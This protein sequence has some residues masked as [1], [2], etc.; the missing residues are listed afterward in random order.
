[1]LL[2]QK[3]FESDEEVRKI[4]N[5]T[6]PRGKRIVMYEEEVAKLEGMSESVS[7]TSALDKQLNKF[8]SEVEI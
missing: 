2:K 3:K 7:I 5:L 1:M 4:K 8:D 6:N